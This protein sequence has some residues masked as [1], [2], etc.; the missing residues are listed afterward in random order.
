MSRRKKDTGQLGLFDPAPPKPVAGATAVIDP[1]GTYRY[2]LGRVLGKGANRILWVML[3]PS[4]ADAL[5]DDNTIRKICGFSARWGYDL[6]E[7]VNLFALRSTDPTALKKHADPIGP[8]NDRHI[9]EA[10]QRANTVVC[11]W[12][13]HGVLGDRDLAVVR[14]IF[15]AGRTPVVLGMNEPSGKPPRAQP[16]HPLYQANEAQVSIWFPSG[17]PKP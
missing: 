2:L 3:N 15:A 8:E 13:N 4:T 16:V 1:T 14:A 12:G 9:L 5:Q 6:L 17:V 11:A 10:V 7:V